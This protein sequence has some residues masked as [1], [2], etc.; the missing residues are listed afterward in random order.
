MIYRRLSQALEESGE[1]EVEY[2]T[3]HPG[4]AV[5]WIMSRA[6]VVDDRDSASA[7]LIG[8]TLDVTEHREAEEERARLQG[9][10]L[11]ARAEA[12]ERE[13]ISRE[14][15]DRVAHSMG[16]AHQS[17]E[18]YEAY[19]KKDPVLAAKKLQLAKESTRRALN[20]T[21][22][23]LSE[24]DRSHVEDTQEGVVAAVRALLETHVPPGVET[25]LSASGGELPVPTLM[26]EQ[27]YLVMREA[28]RNAVAHSG[29]GR[30]RAALEV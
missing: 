25:T 18:L 26:G 22:N 20:Q 19:V 4:G 28:V 30:I 29:G 15:H 5:R 7:R 17:L 3:L 1:F 27:V 8:V 23:L 21:R 16:V 6:R 9:L 11:A 24:L 2:R 14:L 10:E 13:R 12:M